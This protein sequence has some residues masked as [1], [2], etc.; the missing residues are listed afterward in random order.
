MKVSRILIISVLA[1]FCVVMLP[2]F[3]T[4]EEKVSIRGKVKSIDQNTK[5]A[6][7]TTSEGKEVTIAVEDNAT[8]DKFKDGRIGEGDDVKVKYV[9]KEGKNSATYFKKAAG[10]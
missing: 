7:V 8:L 3:A 2:G 1:I 5:T 10:C 6:V 9:I 4:A